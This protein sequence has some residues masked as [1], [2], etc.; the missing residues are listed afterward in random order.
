MLL[1]NT[2]SKRQQLRSL[3]AGGAFVLCVT[4]YDVNTEPTVFVVHR[5]G[6]ITR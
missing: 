1:R 4:L 5:H 6:D 2:N 3:F